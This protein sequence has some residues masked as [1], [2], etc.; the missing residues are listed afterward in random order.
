VES[1][2]LLDALNQALAA[3]FPERVNPLTNN[4]QATVAA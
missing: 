1:Q 2:V 4:S 3:R